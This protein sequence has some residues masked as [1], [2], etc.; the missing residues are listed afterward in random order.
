[1]TEHVE[2]FLTITASGTHFA[3]S[4]EADFFRHVAQE[5]I[6]ARAKTP[7]AGATFVALTK[8]VGELAAALLDWRDP[9]P[10]IYAEAVQV[11]TWAARLATEG[12]ETLYVDDTDIEI[13]REK[14]TPR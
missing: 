2:P 14:Y 5:L 11:A 8:E 10:A 3:Q 12:D 7:D 9:R 6:Y 1:M 13:G 4:P